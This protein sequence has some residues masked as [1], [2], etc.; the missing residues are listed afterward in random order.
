[1]CI[2]DSKYVDYSTVEAA[3]GMGASKIRVFFDVIWPVITPV[4]YTH[5]DIYLKLFL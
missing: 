4:S 3:R 2:R 5:L 1:M